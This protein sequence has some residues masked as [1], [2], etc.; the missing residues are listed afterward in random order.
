MCVFTDY[1]EAFPAP[2]P[3]DEASEP[4]R[5]FIMVSNVK[6]PKDECFFV[7]KG[8]ILR[9]SSGFLIPSIKRHHS[10]PIMHHLPFI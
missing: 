6:M 2:V 4:A 3:L 9:Y 7:L 5:K 10:I 1:K 8:D